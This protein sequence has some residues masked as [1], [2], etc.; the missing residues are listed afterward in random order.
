VPRKRCAGA[1]LSYILPAPLAKN[2]RIRILDRKARLTCAVSLRWRGARDSLRL[3][4]SWPHG[5][6]PPCK[7]FS[8]TGGHR[9]LRTRCY[10]NSLQCSPRIASGS[11]ASGAQLSPNNAG[12]CLR[13]SMKPSS[14]HRVLLPAKDGGGRRWRRSVLGSDFPKTRRRRSAM[15]ALATGRLSSFNEWICDSAERS[16]RRSGAARSDRR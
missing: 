11:G 4:S 9:K 12:Y 13:S 16:K 15:N 6:A 3:P 5:R 1:S 2:I 10:K 8:G 14:G 7:T